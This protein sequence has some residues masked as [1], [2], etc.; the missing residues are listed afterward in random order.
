MKNKLSEALL[1]VAK[2]QAELSRESGI[3]LTTINKLCT[4]N[5]TTTA[6]ELTKTK[7]VRALNSFAKEER[8]SVEEIFSNSAT[9]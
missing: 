7:I 2:S 5:S 6:R 8:H 1:G 3:S 4:G 9:A